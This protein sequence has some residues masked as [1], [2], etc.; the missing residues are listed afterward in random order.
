[1]STDPWLD[2]SNPNGGGV[3]EVDDDYGGRI[4]L[5]AEEIDAIYQNGVWSGPGAHVLN[6]LNERHFF[7]WPKR[8]HITAL[9]GVEVINLAGWPAYFDMPDDH[10]AKAHYRTIAPRCEREI[11]VLSSVLIQAYNGSR[12][13]GSYLHEFE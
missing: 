9:D 6:A 10:P 5:Q 4:R 3:A 13:R 11:P 12:F 8:I 2:L 7:S 1:M